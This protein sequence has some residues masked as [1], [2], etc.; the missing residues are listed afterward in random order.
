MSLEESRVSPYRE[1]SLLE[2]GFEV[3]GLAGN[4]SLVEVE[5]VR[6]ADQL[7]VCVFF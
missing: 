1:T 2:S 4:D 3:V 6:S 5:V 7:A